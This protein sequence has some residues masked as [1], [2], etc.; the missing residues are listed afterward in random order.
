MENCQAINQVYKC[1]KVGVIGAGAAGLAT[2]KELIHEG[3]K[4]TVFEQSMQ[5]GGLWVYDSKVDSDLLGVEPHR[6]RVHSS[7]YASLRTNL[8]REVMSFIDFPFLTQ[9]GRDERRYPSHKEVLLYLEN[10]AKEFDLLHVIQFG[11]S[12]EHVELVTMDSTGEKQWKVVTTRKI[13]GIVDEVKEELFDAMVVCS[14]HYFEPKIANIPGINNWPGKQMHSHNYR[15]AQPFT[16]QVQAFGMDI[17]RNV[18]NVAKEVHLSGR[19]WNSSVDFAKPMGQHQNIW[20]HSTVIR[21]CEDGTVKFKEGSSTMAD[22]IMHCTGYRYYYPFLDTK[23]L[24]TASNIIKPIYQHVFPPS[25]APSL[26]FV[27]LPHK[28]LTFPLFQ[29]QAKWIG[30]VLSGKVKLPPKN[31]MMESIQAFYDQCEASGKPMHQCHDLVDIE[32]KYMDWLADQSGSEHLETWRS[33]MK[34]I[35]FQQ[36]FNNPDTYRD[37]WPDEDLHQEALLCLLKLDI[38]SCWL[39]VHL[40][41]MDQ[42]LF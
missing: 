18:A 19:S 39:L 2:T 31:E 24:V 8:P 29:F 41:E 42:G 13:D 35:A 33:K 23:G 16:N 20:P 1:C 26:S 14:G 5:V 11:T 15:L 32:F 27:G 9:Q 12:V 34:D 38:T 22:V 21:A 40:I 17:S 6:K 36:H 25:L 28:V 30:M 37:Q 3:H 7:V 10:F 4:V